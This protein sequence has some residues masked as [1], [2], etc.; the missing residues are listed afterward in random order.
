VS[1]RFGT[2][3][4][5][6]RDLLAAVRPDDWVNPEPAPRY[7]LV[8]VGAGTAGL[9]TA[10]GAA[11]LGARV[12]LV[13]RH[14][15]GGD[16]LNVGC[17]PSKALL[18]SAGAAAAVRRA[19]ELGVAAGAPTVD[20][21][22][23]MERLRALRAGLAP[24]DGAA[25]FR[26]LGVDVFLGAARFVARDRVEVGGRTLRFARAVIATGG[27]PA[28]PDVP[29]LAAA[30][31]RTNE[32][33]FDLEALPRR[34]AVVGG[35]PIGCEL[36]QA[37]ARL[38]SRVTLIQS[39]P[40]LLPRDDPDAAA[41]VAAAFVAEGIDLRLGATPVEVAKVGADGGAR[42]LR[43]AD[44]AEI[45]ADE[46]LVAAGRLP[47]VEQLGLEVAGVATGRDGVVVDDHLRTANRRIYAAGDV[48]L[49][50]KFTH[51]ADAAARIVIQNALFA[52]RRRFSAAVVPWSTYTDPEVAHVGLDAA[53][54]AARG[55]A[56][57][58]ITI[59]FDE[60]DRARLEGDA[61]GFLRVHAESG[62]GRLLGGTVVGRDAG[63]L[64]AELATAI[65]GRMGLPDLA[66]VIHPYPTRAEAVRKAG[67]AW[68]R[69]RLTPSA[70]R[71]LGAWLR[72]RFGRLR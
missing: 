65:A 68:N 58:T 52:G 67:D 38:G 51:A 8:V 28:V 23:V 3:S 49:S 15:M 42:R 44:G 37:F 7:H 71:L 31:Y 66:A 33:I 14:L 34:L 29:G 24:V 1:R 54:V 45:A 13:E 41:I 6:D 19:A 27:R 4:P 72:L 20:F 70:R 35:G 61:R 69:R 40:R 26:D 59:P 16:C 12:A 18:A 53:E 43:L 5:H 63:D 9:V 2:D 17:V 32:T 56:V 10:A 36:A 57:A 30:G 50:F 47:N 21:P 48:A 55:E 46:I 39:G 22:A 25:R 60:V 11:G 62:S 64:V